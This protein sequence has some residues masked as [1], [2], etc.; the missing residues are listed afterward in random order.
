MGWSSGGDIADVAEKIILKFVPR[1]K[2]FD[3]AAPILSALEA[4]DWDDRDWGELD[5][6]SW[7]SIECGDMK[8]EDYDGEELEEF[9]VWKKKLDKKFGVK[10][11]D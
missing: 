4:Q 6:W 7:V 9:K 1:E 11:G 8:E 3:A 5:I 2:W 10:K